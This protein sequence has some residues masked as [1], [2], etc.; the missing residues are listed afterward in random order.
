MMRWKT[1]ASQR[2]TS[3]RSRI[4]GDQPL[5]FNNLL[6]YMEAG[7]GTPGAMAL[8]MGKIPLI[9]FTAVFSGIC[10]GAELVDSDA[11]DAVFGV[12]A[13]SMVLQD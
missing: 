2:G 6:V 10:L 12:F 3:E 7:R 8:T 11:S 9:L 4:S 13:P 1:R 5:R